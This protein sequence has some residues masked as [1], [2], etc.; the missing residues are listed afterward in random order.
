MLL[1]NVYKGSTTETVGFE[2]ARD[3]LQT[4]MQR[5]NESAIKMTVDDVESALSSCNFLDEQGKFWHPTHLSFEGFVAR[6]APKGQ[7]FDKTY[8]YFIEK[9]P[10]RSK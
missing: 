6:L 8:N 3:T 7:K 10:L 1:Y 4:F 2:D 9:L 5:L